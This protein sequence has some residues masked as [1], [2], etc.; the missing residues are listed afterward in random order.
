MKPSFTI[1]GCGKVGVTLGKWLKV[2]GYRATGISSKSPESLKKA[3]EILKPAHASLVPWE[4]T[5]NADIVFIATPDDTIQATCE[6]TAAQKGFHPGT[7]VLHLSGVLTSRI[8]DSARSCNALV[9]SMH[10]LQSF[11]KIEEKINPFQ[12]II[13][14]AEGD[15][16]ACQQAERI[17]NDLGSRYINIL[18][19]QKTLYHG[20]AV[21]ASNYL[22]TL[23]EMALKMME[24]AGID[25]KN[26]FQ[27]LLPLIR[28]TLTNIEKIGIPEA[29]TGPIARGD[30]ATVAQ[31]IDKL[32]QELNNFTPL[33]KLLGQYTVDIALAKKAITDQT[34]LTLKKALK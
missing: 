4:V 9:G 27:V 23:I 7:I 31:H 24:C 19:D 26:A 10:P 13:I 16:K 22:V 21:V 12:N 34:A 1:I 5:G 20:S 33:K 14:A 18:T 3:T 2:N 6:K 17:S 32:N 29:L 11:A 28:G 8:L 15:K 30:Q 25:K